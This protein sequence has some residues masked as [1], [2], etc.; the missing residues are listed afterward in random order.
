MKNIG[1]LGRMALFLAGLWPVDLA[2]GAVLG[3]KVFDL[4]TGQPI[5]EARVTVYPLEKLRDMPREEECPWDR[6]TLTDPEGVYRL[7]DLAPEVVVCGVVAQG[8]VSWKRNT[9][10]H[11]VLQ[12]GIVNRCDMGLQP[13]DI[14]ELTVLD[15]DLRPVENAEV[16]VWTLTLS[17]VHPEKTDAQGQVRVDKISRY[18]L[19]S[20]K[21]R[22][23]GYEEGFVRCREFGPD[24]RSTQACVILKPDRVEEQKIPGYFKGTVRTSEGVPLPELKVAWGHVRD[25]NPEC[26]TT[27][28]AGGSYLLA[29]QILPGWDYSSNWISVSGEG[30]APAGEMAPSPGSEEKPFQIDFTLSSAHWIEGIVCDPSDQP[31]EGIEVEAYFPDGKGIPGVPTM[32]KTD[33]KGQFRIEGLPG[34]QVSL[35]LFGRDLQSVWRLEADVDQSRRI[36][37]EPLN[38]VIGCVK[39]LETGEPVPYFTVKHYAVSSFGSSSSRYLVFSR[40]Y[41]SPEGR[42]TFKYKEP[43]LRLTLLSPGFLPAVDIPFNDL[44]PEGKETPVTLRRAPVGGLKGLVLDAQTGQPVSGASVTDAVGDPGER[45]YWS[46]ITETSTTFDC[47]LVQ[48]TRTGSD[49]TFAFVEGDEKGLL[50]ILA[51]GYARLAIR[52]DERPG[53]AS[54]C[55]NLEIR[56]LPGA[57]VSGHCSG[58]EEIGSGPE[59]ELRRNGDREESLWIAPVVQGCFVWHNLAPGSYTLDELR[60]R[61]AEWGRFRVQNEFELRQGETQDVDL[62][63]ES[64]SFALSGHVSFD[65]PWAS[66]ERV[67]QSLDVVLTPM[68][69]WTCSKIILRP[70]LSGYFR[71]RGLRAGQYLLSTEGG[72]FRDHKRGIHWEGCE[73]NEIVTISKDTVHDIQLKWKTQWMDE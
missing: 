55:G 68:F 45:L 13:E 1:S 22:K 62:T 10:H 61:K 40:T 32:I 9:A 64:G 38:Q 70:D 4:E 67:Y 53:F 29:M 19:S 12:E 49:G 52:P 57:S 6:E 54:A 21:A 35:C 56:L 7:E 24:S 3:G 66:P 47:D 37:M 48:R 28:D 46:P 18:S 30:W 44:S 51:P 2:H 72:N 36:V 5:S 33:E 71:L 63:E 50:F 60:D 15:Q 31:L 41:T 17:H 14:V 39:D 42:F 69:P 23:E 58:W 34:P 25:V 16:E 65:N 27:T 20:L 59:F 11:A 73:V 43:S 8:Y 26:S